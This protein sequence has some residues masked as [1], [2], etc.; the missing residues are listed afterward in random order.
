VFGRVGLIVPLA[1]A[2][3][4][5]VAR[6]LA[7]AVSSARIARWAGTRIAMLSRTA[8]TSEAMPMPRHWAR[9]KVRGPDQCTTG[10]CT[11]GVIEDGEAFGRKI[12]RID[13]QRIETRPTLRFIN[14]R[15]R[16]A[17]GGI[18]REVVDGYGGYGYRAAQHVS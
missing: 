18:G 5:G 15:H 2:L 11:S 14:P 3:A 12:E 16:F 7:E 1:L 8:V 6:G 13:D 9:A 4:L 10:H 17:V